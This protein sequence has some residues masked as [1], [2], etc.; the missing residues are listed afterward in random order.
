MNY[1][2]FKRVTCFLL[3]LLCVLSIPAGTMIQAAAIEEM[4]EQELEGD[5]FALEETALEEEADL[6]DAGES[7]LIQ[8]PLQEEPETEGSGEVP[9]A[10]EEET[11]WLDIDGNFIAPETLTVYVLSTLAD[12]KIEQPEF[13]DKYTGMVAFYDYEGDMAREVPFFFYYEE[14]VLKSEEEGFV[15]AKGYLDLVNPAVSSDVLIPDTLLAEKVYAGEEVFVNEETEAEYLFG[16]NLSEV[17][18]G[19]YSGSYNDVVY[20]DGL[21]VEEIPPEPIDRLTPETDAVSKAGGPVVSWNVDETATGYRI[22]RKEAKDENWE[23][24]ADVSDPAQGSYVDASA[25]SNKTY[26][27]A[28]RSFF[29]TEMGVLPDYESNDWSDYLQSAE[30]FYLEA[31]VISKVDNVS[32]G[33]K[34]TWGKVTGAAKYR[35]YRKTTEATAWSNLGDVT[36]TSFTDKTVE[37]GVRYLYT[38]RAFTA[39]GAKSDYY[40]YTGQTNRYVSLHTIPTV[41]TKSVTEGTEC[42]IRVDWTA[43]AAAVSYRIFRK[44]GDGS[45]VTVYNTPDAS[46]TTWFDNDVVSDTTYYYTVRTFYGTDS[47]M[48]QWSSFT[49]SAARYHLEAPVITSVTSTTTGMEIKWD[50]VPGAE[51]YIVYRKTA[52]ATG[53]SKLGTVTGA[54]N[55]KYLDKPTGGDEIYFYTVRAKNSKL[56]SVY[57]TPETGTLYRAPHTVKLENRRTDEGTDVIDISWT[58]SIDAVSYRIYRREFGETSWQTLVDIPEDPAVSTTARSYRDTN[59]EAGVT[60]EYAVRSKYPDGKWNGYSA[61]RRMHLSSPVVTE[62]SNAA[63]GIKVKWTTTPHATSYVIYRRTEDTGWGKVGEV[64]GQAKSQYVDT[65][66]AN[67]TKYYYTVCAK[68]QDSKKANH[69]SGFL[70]YEK[71]IVYH[72]PPAVT[73]SVCSEGLQ[74]KWATESTITSFRLFRK[75]P[76]QTSWEVIANLDPSVVNYVDATPSSGDVVSYALRSLHDDGIWSHYIPV[77]YTYLPAAQLSSPVAANTSNGVKVTWSMVTGAASYRIYRKT[78]DTGWSKIGEVK[79]ENTLVYTD[80]SKMT[81]GTVYYYTVRPMGADG[82]MGEYDRVGMAALYLPAPNNLFVDSP[83]KTEGTSISWNAVAGAEEYQIWRKPMKGSWVKVDTVTDTSYVDVDVRDKSVIYYYAI[84]AVGTLTLGDTK[85]TIAGAYDTTGVTFAIKWSGSERNAWVNKDG[86][87]YYV[88]KNGY[89]YIGWHYIN[90]NGR[91]NKYYFDLETGVL[92]TNLYQEFGKSYRDLKCMY[93]VCINSNS[94]NPSTTTIYLYDSETKSYCIPA[95][96]VRCVGSMEFTRATSS[97]YLRKATGQRWL[98]NEELEGAAFE[99]YAVFIRGTSSWLHSALYSSKSHKSFMSFTYNSLRSNKNNSLGCIRHQCIYA[100]L[101]C[102]I[103]RN[104]YGVRNNIPVTIYR[105]YSKKPP[106]GVPYMNK[107]GSRNTDPTDPVVTG[108][109]FYPTT[110]FGISTKGGASTWLYY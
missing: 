65:T 62:V 53:W 44:V 20:Q 108:K 21:A 109:F 89:C 41:T 12:G 82:S 67:A 68:A 4:N 71:P 63:D 31:P 80:G 83:V 14:G 3:A 105:N 92:C 73:V 58:R 28:V 22:F 107:I 59:V 33:L 91:N 110:T 66:A 50:A 36:G 85:Y 81:A 60:Y 38:V 13:D 48:A 93:V 39:G 34:L 15:F 7:E 106:F 49:S 86:K 35:V 95:V 51:S 102:D 2:W 37:Q 52:A 78:E 87:Q 90:R 8:Q 17:E 18:N 40:D 11:S 5:P 16:V 70:G 79:G 97:A 42:G 24:L 30:I 32:G 72:A 64:V 9:A 19:L 23:I 69:M 77:S 54:K 25:L 56:T 74:L 47:L 43:D 100:F 88:D 45:W 98:T 94:S 75:L 1:S 57:F 76:G 96:S 84:K 55:T 6:P 10:V 29:G 99:Q 26:I 103:Q 27:Y 101:F 61:F 46:S 104:G